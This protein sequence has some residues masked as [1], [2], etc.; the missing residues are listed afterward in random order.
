MGYGDCMRFVNYVGL[1]LL[2]ERVEGIEYV[3]V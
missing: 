3:L 1:S 2:K